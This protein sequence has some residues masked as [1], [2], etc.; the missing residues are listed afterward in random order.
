MCSLPWSANCSP[1][2]LADAW[3]ANHA[4][5]PAT[6]MTAT[7]DTP[8][9]IRRRAARLA[10]LCCCDLV[11]GFAMLLDPVIGGSVWESNPPPTC[12]EP[13]TGFEVR[14]AH[15]VPRRFRCSSTRPFQPKDY[16]TG[17][18]DRSAAG[19]WGEDG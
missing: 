2:L 12:L 19:E 8:V 18:R 4:M 5:M 17:L 3:Y 13:D 14:E 6:T 7:I 16:T 15:R 9:F 10:P 1:G 11:C